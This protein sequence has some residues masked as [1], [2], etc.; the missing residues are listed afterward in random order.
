MTDYPAKAVLCD[1]NFSC[2][3]LALSLLERGHQLL[4]CGNLSGDPC[5][6][7]AHSSLAI[8]YSDEVSLLE[9]VCET[10]ARYLVAG[11]NDRSYLSCAYVAE[12][13]GLPGYDS[14]ETALQLHEK[15]RFRAF[16]TR[17]HYPIPQIFDDI[18][19]VDTTS[20]PV[21]VK[22]TDAFSGRGISKVM[23]AAALPLAL[24]NAR[25]FSRNGCAVVEAFVEGSLHSHSAFIRDGKIALDFFVDEFC[26]VYDY[27]VNS[28]CMSTSLEEQL[29]KDV[30]ECIGQMVA[31]LGLCDGLLHTQFIAKGERFWLIE[32]T[33]RCPGDLYSHLIRCATGVNYA[34]FY[35]NGFLGESVPNN[36]P[37]GST[38]YIG[39]HTAST[40]KSGHLFGLRHT[41]PAKDV[42]MLQFK[43]CGSPLKVAP[44]DKAALF[45]AEFD[46]EREMASIT[47][48]LKNF[49]VLDMLPFGDEP[50]SIPDFSSLQS[51]L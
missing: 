27:Q 47:P 35:V 23:N 24:Q 37:L 17:Q 29:R 4:V 19:A 39:R 5:H 42:Q 50:A 32:L 12:R 22:P 25:T 31:E 41:I 30:R 26:T 14:Y 20:F 13:L 36:S 10:G 38:R 46:S 51:S 49:I 43:P 3:P 2:I 33:R 11:C 21:L 16:A 45:F 9:T 48:N 7:Y 1:A 8:D 18:V 15:D 44:F 40:N 34:A 6:R 28:S